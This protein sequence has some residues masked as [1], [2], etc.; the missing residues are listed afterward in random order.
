MQE[1][2]N[3]YIIP[4]MGIIPEV[5]KQNYETIAKQ[6]REVITNALDAQ[7][8]NVYLTVQPDGRYTNLVISDDGIG[9]DE[10][11]FK[12]QFLALGG[13]DRYYDE[14]K[15]GRIGI[16]FLACAPL[17]EFIEIHTR[18][19]GSNLAFEARLNNKKL[20]DRSHRLKEIDKFPVGKILKIFDNADLIGLENHYT[21]IVLKKLHSN[22][23]DSF[24]PELKDFQKLIAQLRKI[25]PLKFPENC[26]LFDN[27]SNELKQILIG[28]SDTWNINVYFN[29]E[30]LTKRVYGE[31][32][33]N[34]QFK[35]VM[36]LIKEKAGIG[37]VSGYFIDNNRKIKNWNGLIT[38]FQ[39][40][41]VE[42]SGFLG[43]NIRLAALPRITG[44]LFISGLNK[45]TAI[46]INRNAFN[47]AD[48]DYL[49]LKKLIYEKLDVFTSTHYRRSY[50]SSAI[51]KEI[52]KKTSIRKDLKK[53]SQAISKPKKK[54]KTIQKKIVKKPPIKKK[55]TDLSE[56]KIAKRF[57]DVEVKPIKKVPKEGRIR[58]GYTIEWKGE[59]GTKPI[60]YIE[61]ELL[62]E[63]GKD[64]K[65]KNKLYKVYFIE[66]E[67]DPEPC[68]IDFDKNEVNFN[69]SHPCLK[70]RN[71]KIISFIFILTY[72][73]DKTKTKEEY[74][75]KIIDSLT[76]I[77]D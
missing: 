8:E 30:L 60:V 24:N 51:N 75:N 33:A 57:G 76:Q 2:D 53:I 18:K 64:L 52:K 74:K 31:D 5:S 66:D 50:I 45:N 16:G 25:L 41:T 68:K 44:E 28:E 77:G 39:N 21:R 73:F 12:G 22:V 61:N 15:I 70:K 9:M 69:I 72:F 56:L 37:E 63:S 58:K 47:E 29:G 23:I 19:K 4:K 1:G 7:A 71:E 49:I 62:K 43:W 20:L 46:V 3:L 40:I 65:I 32:S 34:E 14:N 35:F 17:C 36:E 6:L 55:A 11:V 38:R 67:E 27:I 59:N 26:K 42:D 54:K 10:E 48:E 13:S